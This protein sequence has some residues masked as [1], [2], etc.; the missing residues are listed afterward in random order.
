VLRLRI[1]AALWHAQGN[2]TSI[3]DKL[4]PLYSHQFLNDNDDSHN[5]NGGG[6]DNKNNLQG[7]VCEF[8]QLSQ[9]TALV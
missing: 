7:G 6:G 3:F 2:F 5:D 8:V 4:D 9:K 1:S